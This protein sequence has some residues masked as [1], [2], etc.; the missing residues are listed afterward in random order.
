MRYMRVM[1]FF[2]LPTK[3]KEDKHHYVTFRN[4]LLRDGFDMLQYSV[5]TRLC[6]N[7]D[8]VDKFVERVRRYTPSDGSVRV[9]TVTNKQFAD[10]AILAGKKTNNEKR[11]THQSLTLF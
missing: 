7:Y 2:D 3:E 9:M 4:R 6:G 1:V 8:A 5:Y 11:I 10:M